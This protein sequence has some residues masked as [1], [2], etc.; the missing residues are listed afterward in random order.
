MGLL[1][2]IFRIFADSTARSNARIFRAVF[3]RAEIFAAVHEP[4]L[5]LSG[6]VLVARSGFFL[7]VFVDQYPFEFLHLLAKRACLDRSVVVMRFCG[8]L[9]VI[10]L[11]VKGSN[12]VWL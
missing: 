5:R 10:L 9:A 3:F 6:S 1:A 2:S 4:V 7:F 8:I 11:A 12:V